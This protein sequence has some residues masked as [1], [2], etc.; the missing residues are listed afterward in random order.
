MD[1]T[2]NNLVPFIKTWKLKDGN[3]AEKEYWFNPAEQIA[4]LE[5]CRIRRNGKE[6]DCTKIFYTDRYITLIGSV[7]FFFKTC[8]DASIVVCLLSDLIEGGYTIKQ[9]MEQTNKINDMNF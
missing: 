9:F 7:E 2:N 4:G 1:K 3:Y 6:V 5:E 8:R